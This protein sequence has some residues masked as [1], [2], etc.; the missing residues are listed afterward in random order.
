MCKCPLPWVP[1]Y[2]VNLFTVISIFVYFYLNCFFLNT[3]NM[4]NIFIFL[5]LL[6]KDWVYNTC[7]YILP[8]RWK[9]QSTCIYLYLQSVLFHFEVLFTYMCSS[10]ILC[11]QFAVL[12]FRPQHTSVR[13]VCFHPFEVFVFSQIPVLL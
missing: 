12:P 3:I 2:R 9:V 10:H 4:F 6:L 13:N 8:Q 5:I 1:Y 11:L 7:L